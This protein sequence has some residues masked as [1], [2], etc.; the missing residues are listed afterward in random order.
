[1]ETDILSTMFFFTYGRELK[2][3]FKKKT[4]KVVMSFNSD[5]NFFIEFVTITDK[6]RIVKLVFI[7]FIRNIR[8]KLDKNC[9][10]IR[11]LNHKQSFYITSEKTTKLKEILVHFRKLMN[12]VKQFKY[13]IHSRRNLLFNALFELKIFKNKEQAFKEKD[14][15][16]IM[17]AL[18]IK[19]KKLKK[20]KNAKKSFYSKNN[21]SDLNY[22][23]PS[24]HFDEDE[25]ID[26]F[27]SYIKKKIQEMTS[28]GKTDINMDII[29]SVFQILMQKNELM[30]LYEK[31]NK[32]NMKNKNP[33]QK[34]DE[35]KLI[36]GMINDTLSDID[37][38]DDELMPF[39]NFL[40]F[41]REVQEEVIDADTID[42][43][44]DFFN[45]IRMRHIFDKREEEVKC[46]SFNEFCTFMFSKFNSLF[47]PNKKHRY[48]KM[49]LPI[50]KYFVSSSHNTYL[51]GHQLYGKSGLEG[52]QR[53]V[54]MGF[55]CLEIDCWDGGK[56]EPVVTHGRTL[57]KNYS[58]KKI[59]KF[60]SEIA[61]KNNKYPLILSLEMHCNAKQRDK[62]AY[63]II[64]YFKERL[65]VLKENTIHKEYTVADLIG[66][67][68]IKT[69]S[70]YPSDFKVSN[71]SSQ[72]FKNYHD[73]TLSYITSIFKEKLDEKLFS[74][75]NS[76]DPHFKTGFGIMS[77]SYTKFNGLVKTQV[78]R[79]KFTQFSKNNMIRIYPDGT[80]I[81]SSNFNPLRLWETGCQMVCLNLQT[82]DEAVLLNLIKFMENG[83]RKCGYIKKPSYLLGDNK[84][85]P[86]SRKY[87]IEII[88][89][90]TLTKNL[91]DEDDFLEVYVRGHYKDE[92]LNQKVYRLGVQCN[93]LQ[94]VLLKDF[95]KSIV[96]NIMFPELAFFI[97]KLRSKNGFK[98]IGCIPVS[99][100]R[101]GFR[102]L[103]LYDED[104]FFNKYSYLLLKVYRL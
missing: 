36:K 50:S 10:K 76:K 79:N 78:G 18:K 6:L 53:A 69:D 23:I 97:F 11:M 96:F 7:P 4:Y 95:N 45:H 2:I 22:F 51:V 87:W 5:N 100:V 61:F 104:L 17:N 59:I 13:A 57:T 30:R 84:A 3:I 26:N 64:E 92:M 24:T 42:D 29:E 54:E 14:V 27:Y 28:N 38:E 25:E 99:C 48:Q 102:V 41:L 16:Q 39:K 9:L 85:L 37:H 19:G 47:D 81:N 52:Y 91:W 31:Y 68:L 71:G 44:T 65:F 12:Y 89:V 66:K 83:G 49:N 46:I 63:Y 72:K 1:M 103:S 101:P 90:Q 67:V 77:L 74:Q 93:F 21:D 73:D 82:P 33:W 15:K 62:I 60:L 35:H 86:K 43:Y 88:S 40:S 34:T 58:F 8:I 80:K 75:P 55:R 98:N 94:P 20:L 56:G 70:S 32:I